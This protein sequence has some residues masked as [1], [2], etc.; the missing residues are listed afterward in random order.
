MEFLENLPHFLDK[1]EESSWQKTSA[2][3]DASAKIYGYR[4]DSVYSE[5]FRLNSGLHRT[6]Q[7]EIEN[8]IKN[9][10]KQEMN[11]KRERRHEGFCTIEKDKSKLNLNSYD[12]EFEVDPLFKN[13]TAKF[14]QSGARGLLL[15]TLP[16]DHNMKV[17]LEYK[18]EAMH[19][20]SNNITQNIFMIYKGKFF[21]YY[22]N[23][24]F[25]RIYF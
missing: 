6:E 19:K 9:P 12:L 16:I 13:M 23:F 5:T 3:L 22:F 1:K 4:V 2:F 11:I 17:L 15:R 14:N 20:Q 7:K 10:L 8:L 21:N 18:H 24:Y 25:I